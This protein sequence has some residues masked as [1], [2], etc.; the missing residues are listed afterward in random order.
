MP[1]TRD[2]SFSQGN[3]YS[4]VLPA[5]DENGSPVPLTGSALTGIIYTTPLDILWNVGFPVQNYQD[6]GVL[7]NFDTS[8]TSS[9]PVGTLKYAITKTTPELETTTLY[10]GTMK[11]LPGISAGLAQTQNILSALFYPRYSNPEGYLKASTAGL[12][13]NGQN[14][15]SGIIPIY[16]TGAIRITGLG[17]AIYITG[18]GGGTNISFNSTGYGANLGLLDGDTLYIKSLSGVSGAAVNAASD[19]TVFIATTL[20]DDIAAATAATA[21]TGA[22]LQSSIINLQLATGHLRTVDGLLSGQIVSASGTLSAN[23]AVL[24]AQLT[25]VS[26]QLTNLSASAALISG[27][28]NATKANLIMVSG[29]AVGA[30]A[31][32]V[33]LSANVSYLNAATGHLR[34]VDAIL[35]GY[36]VSTSGS[37]VQKETALYGSIETVSGV[38]NTAASNVG[39]LSGYVDSTFLM[40][41]TNLRIISGNIYIKDALLVSGW[42]QLSCYNG[43]LGL[44]NLIYL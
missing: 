44:S 15:Y 41:P 7:I 35:S 18:Q 8:F 1:I 22:L 9:L 10:N 17:N 24:T 37:L 25:G 33:T 27:D 26:G 6:T 19:G 39:L 5:I 2:I 4:E 38:A 20:E 43:A 16:G 34:N 13:I 29:I 36:I 23:D 21:A 31:T 32:G 42:Y 14:Y 12:L 40:A 11:V 30:A 28:L 3:T